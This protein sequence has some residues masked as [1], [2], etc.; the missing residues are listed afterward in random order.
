MPPTAHG[1]DEGFRGIGQ[2]IDRGPRRRGAR[3]NTLRE[4][5]IMSEQSGTAKSTVVLVHGAWADA[6]SW[7]AAIA[8]LQAAGQTVNAPPNPLRSLASDA[9]TI[10]AF[11]KAIPGPVILVGHS[12]GGAVISVA[13]PGCTNVK[14]LVYVDGF[15]P[16]E[17]ESCLSI[18][19]QSPGAP[20]DLFT[21]VPLANGTSTS[22]LH[23]ST[24]EGCSRPTSRRPQ[25]RSWR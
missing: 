10:A 7:N 12:Y 19:P 23:R 9:A 17:G 25:R 22:T 2:G 1:D 14:A 24:S 8:Q 11:V 6:T 20:P 16:D 15:A 21:P 4:E 3:S 5:E 18:L 13:S